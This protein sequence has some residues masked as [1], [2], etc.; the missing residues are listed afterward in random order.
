[1]T[2]SDQIRYFHLL[3]D[4]EIRDLRPILEIM[5]EHR[6][7]ILG[8]W[9]AL[10][11]EHFGDAKTLAEPA[12]REVYG[13]DLDAVLQNLLHGD[14]EGL[15]A[16]VR[17]LG[18]EFVDR[19][20]PFAE[21]VASMHLFE[22]SAAEQF[23]SRLKVLIKGPSIFLTFDKLSHC[24][25]ILLAGSYF[26][27]HQSTA[28]ARLVGLEREAQALA[29]GVAGRANFHGL[30]GRSAVMR[31]VYEQI[32]AAAGGHGAVL[33]AGESG[34]GK[35]LVA[36]ALHACAGGAANRPFV[37]LNCAALPR[38]LIESELFGHRRGAYTGAH[39]E[40]EGLIRAASEGTLFLDEITEMAPETQPKLL[41]VIDERTVRPV[42]TTREMS[43]AVRFIASTNRDPEKSVE[44]G[45][46][47]RDLFYRLNVHRLLVPPL[48]ERLEDV[49]CL[50]DHFVELFAGRGLRR[51]E[52]VTEEAL[53]VLREYAWPGNVRELKNAIEHAL[54]V[55][56]G[57]RIEVSDLPSYVLR[58]ARPGA[59]ESATVTA[60]GV[61]TL[62]QGERDLIVRALEV[63]GGNKLQ[64]A[65]LLRISRHR[66][67]DKLKKFGL[68]DGIRPSPVRA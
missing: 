2:A 66:L 19:G 49:A 65:R 29:G 43:V 40:Y 22:E 35:E 61:P 18:Y 30:V 16:D 67:Y 20:V 53:A 15:E 50:C 57:P 33:I 11:V 45:L 1:M 68:D 47:R 5:Q 36:R 17:A 26:A 6:D 54:T 14:M 58:G 64:A 9:H 8:R 41:R 44:A 4:A 12:F 23:Q 62:E 59:H 39:T 3:S 37:A 21:V 63:T 48:R 52:G 32:A 60:S 46:L 34:S 7:E 25:M 31:R 38:E 56:K 10:Y 51:V 24:R 27:G 42:G 13:R 55:V 28:S